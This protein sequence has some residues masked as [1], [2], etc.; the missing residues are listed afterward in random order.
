MVA[1]TSVTPAGSGSGTKPGG[2]PVPSLAAGPTVPVTTKP[3]S[4]R[5]APPRTPAG[6]WAPW[7][8]V[9]DVAGARLWPEASCLPELADGEG[10]RTRAEAAT[11]P[12][13]TTDSAAS[14][15]FRRVPHRPPA[16][17]GL[18]TILAS[19]A[20]LNGGPAPRMH[21][22]HRMNALLPIGTTVPVLNQ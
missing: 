17:H 18:A 8:T 2:I 4:R 19:D 14:T 20:V 11:S 6:A 15:R 9:F 16:R 7:C 5:L 21:G 3:W 10:L 22:G 1:V 12:M 13:T